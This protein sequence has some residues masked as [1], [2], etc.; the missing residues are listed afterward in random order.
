MLNTPHV[1]TGAAIGVA[2]GNPFVAFFGAIVAH[3]VLDAVPHTDPGTWHMNEPYPFKPHAADMALGFLDVF[4]AFYLFVYLSGHAPLIAGAPIAGVIGGIL[5]DIFGIAPLFVPRLATLKGYDT[6]LEF[7]MKLHRT[8]RPNQW[9]L[10]V[11]T[12][13]VV[14]VVAVWYLLG[15]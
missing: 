9:P 13:L 11:V 5:P 4:V 15:S 3:Y 10:G 8:A 1:L 6:F 14:I 7:S 12:Q 2:T